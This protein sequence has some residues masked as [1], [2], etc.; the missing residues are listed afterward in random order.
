M[1]QERLIVLSHRFLNGSISHEE[2]AE[3]HQAITESSEYREQLRDQ[4]AMHALIER[5]FRHSKFFNKR[6][7][8]ALRDPSQKKGAI[9][10]IMERLDPKRP[11][12][13]GS[14]QKTGKRIQPIQQSEA[15]RSRRHFGG[16]GVGRSDPGTSPDLPLSTFRPRRR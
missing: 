3:L 12:A 8:A 10:R 16:G 1:T 5:R 9:T 11:Q 13:P 7:R 15:R 6:V 4:V 14:S 2:A